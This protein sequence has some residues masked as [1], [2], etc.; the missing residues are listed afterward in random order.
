MFIRVFRKIYFFV[1]F[2]MFSY[3]VKYQ[4]YLKFRFFSFKMDNLM[5]KRFNHGERKLI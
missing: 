4:V 3:P 2:V 1:T 5:K